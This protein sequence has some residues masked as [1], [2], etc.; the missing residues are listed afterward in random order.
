ME[1]G[2]GFWMYFKD[3]REI[4]ILLLSEV[5]RKIYNGS[6]NNGTLKHFF[7]WFQNL[8]IYLYDKILKLF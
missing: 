5:F 3:T 2:T 7:L 6:G 8:T 4:K 1:I